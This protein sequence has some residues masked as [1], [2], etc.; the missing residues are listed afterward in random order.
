MAPYECGVRALADEGDLAGARRWFEAAYVEAESAG[1][2]EGMA[3]AMVG[4]GGLWVHEHRAS[5]TAGLFEARLAHVSALV[6]AD[7]HRYG[8]LGLRLRIRIAGE[9]AYRTGRLET[10]FALLDEARGVAGPAARIEA[11]SIAHHCVLGPAH[12]RIRR[13]LAGELI[14]VAAGTGQR[15]PIV[16]GLLWQ[17]VNLLLAGHRHAG[18]RLAE[19]RAQLAEGPYLAADFVVSAIDVMLAIR[20]GRLEEAEQRA[21]ECY[22]LGVKAGDVDVEGWYAGQLATIR[23]YQGRLP[24][25]LSMLGSTAGAPVLSVV[26]DSLLAAVAVAAAQAGDRARAEMALAALTGAG[27]DRPVRSSTWLVTMFGITEAAYLLDGRALAGRAYDLLLPFAQLPAVVSLG[28]ACFGSVEQ[29]LGVAALT[30]GDLDRAVGH[31]RE[32]VRR[33]RALGH[34]PAVRVSLLRLAEALDLRG[35]PGDAVAAAAQR[36]AADDLDPAESARWGSVPVPPV[37]C[38][39]EGRTWRVGLGTRSVVVDHV[40]GMLHLAVLTANPGIEIPSIELV[41]GAE[42]LGRT[43]SAPGQMLLDPAAVHSYRRRLAELS[44]AIDDAG[45]RGDAASAAAMT[46]ERD[47]VRTQLGTGTGLAGRRRTFTDDGERARLAV[48]RAIRRAVDRIHR[49]DPVIGA[50]LRTS[51]HSGMRCW[52]R[53][54]G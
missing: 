9:A 53:P 42:A 27:L 8:D 31:L 20:A 50:H 38:V 48:G 47:W 34:R 2:V 37:T 10:I 52:Y 32:A 17:V 36:A 54:V 23:W 45:H 6:A 41:A 46:R 13:R 22:E 7:P 12:G 15:G 28:V 18:R 19:L 26:D 25:L 1:D 44:S 35:G 24:E 49:A 29:A 39:R 3:R 14:G 21:Q 5:V 33:N 16:M 43:R 40:V 4:Y 11:L 51:V 30:M